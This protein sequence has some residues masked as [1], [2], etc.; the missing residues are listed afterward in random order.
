MNVLILT[1]GTRG[2]VQPFVALGKALRERGH[3]VTLATS[4]RFES[5]V[6]AHGL[7]FAGMSDEML[8]LLDTPA[9][10]HMVENTRTIF[11]GL[12]NGLR[13]SRRIRPM[14]RDQIADSWI[15][16][17]ACRPDVV[18][19]HPKGFAGP[20]I[21]EACDCPALLVLPFPMLV[22]TGERP[23]IGF[24]SLPLG[25]RANRLTYRLVNALSSIPMKGPLEAFRSR[26]GLPRAK[27]LDVLHTA[28]GMRIPALTA[29]SPTVVPEPEDWAPTDCMV[30]YW[31][32]DEG[33]DWTPPKDLVAFLD[34]GPP[35]VYV[36]FGSMAGRAPERRAKIVVEALERTG[37][38]GI[39]ATGW[40]GLAPFVESTSI[41]TIESAPHAWILPRTRAAV[42]HG[43]AGTTA[44]ALRAGVPSI[45]VPFMG[46]QPFW[47]ARVESLGAGPPPIP[48]KR[49]TVARLEAAI[50]ATVTDE[51]MQATAAALGAKI[52]EEDGLGR[53]CRFIE[54][55][56]AG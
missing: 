50:R 45:V 7:R 43:G 23:H 1:Y 41:L 55:L 52:R 2:D 11:D 31:F 22:P 20:T 9:G 34:E 56:V 3:V 8:S 6:V 19:Y 25:L 13:F 32:L 26:I 15:A 30:G 48:Q 54:E 12:R 4:T 24:P 29:V 42:H 44:A 53:A 49:L 27:R 28:E 38:R 14:L 47:G 37:Q 18:V 39:V 5:F 36:G 16:A 51:A 10:K 46:D 21:A 17:R 40:G 35:P 33:D